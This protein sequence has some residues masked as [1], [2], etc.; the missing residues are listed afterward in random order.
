MSISPASSVT[1]AEASRLPI[2]TLGQDDFL[3]LVV[4]QLTTQDPLNP[5]KDTEFIAQ[6]AQFSQ[7]EQAKSM[8]TDLAA[9]R[10]DQA[11]LQ[12]NSML[13]RSVELQDPQGRVTQG[14]VTAVRFV[15]GNPMIVVDGQ[16]HFLGEVISIS[17]APPDPVVPPGN[18]TPT[19]TTIP[20]V[21]PP[22]TVTPVPP[23]A[24]TVNP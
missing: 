7:L 15:G 6:M 17:P 19:Q 11:F 3:K 14:T 10:S 13:G 12:A 1:N 5:Q 18:M 4:A 21:I 23:I 20:P 24:V 16:N 9:L 8:Q 2:R 22:V